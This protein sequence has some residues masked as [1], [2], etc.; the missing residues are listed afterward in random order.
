[1]ES[2]QPI[3]ESFLLPPGSIIAVAI[4]GFFI[5]GKWKWLGTC[6]IGLSVAA[7]VALSLP[8]TSREL[9][10]ALE[11]STSPLYAD[12]LE[13][14]KKQAGAIV[15]LGAGRYA[16]AP[17]YGSDTVSRFA[18]ERLRYAARLHQQTGL[19]ILVAGGS[20]GGEKIPE[21][22][23][24]G[25]ALQRDFGITPRWVETRSRNTMENAVSAAQLLKARGI[26]HVIL[27]THAWHMQRAEW[28][29][30]AAGLQVTAAPTGFNT[31]SERER[32]LTG[33]L[34]SAK[35]LYWT[36]MALHERLGYLWYRWR[37]PPEKLP[38]VARALS[39]P[40][41]AKTSGGK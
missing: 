10:S 18:L 35:G 11:A 2:W 26:K 33:Y 32:R 30:K 29:F 3:I 15:V 36:S 38:G 39:G 5:Y 28:A 1:V 27:V 19:P 12:A 16:D 17:E 31:L 41:K 21:A 9:T 34:P 24:M 8:F 6:I 40:T 23:L 22:K 20:T 37:Y 4:L 25:E 7:L 14:A 13:D